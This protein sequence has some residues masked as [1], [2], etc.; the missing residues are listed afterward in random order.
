MP[1]ARAPLPARAPSSRDDIAPINI[2]QMDVPLPDHLTPW[3]KKEEEEG[4]RAMLIKWPASRSQLRTAL[5][6]IQ[7]VARGGGGDLPSS[8]TTAAGTAT[9]DFRSCFLAHADRMK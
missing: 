8:E 7:D 2:E 1:D 4:P 9:V 3:K 6:V 5:P